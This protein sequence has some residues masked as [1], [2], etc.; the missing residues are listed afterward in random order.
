MTYCATGVAEA[1]FNGDSSV[2]Q[3]S[4]TL[5]NTSQEPLN[6]FSL[7]FRTRDSNATVIYLRHSVSSWIVSLQLSSG[8]LQIVHDVGASLLMS[9]DASVADGIW[10]DVTVKFTDNITSLMIDGNRTGD[11]R[12]LD[13][14]RQNVID[15]N[16]EVF[17]GV[18]A[19][20]SNHF[21]GCLDKV[22]IN[23]LLLPFFRRVELAN[24]TSVERFDAVRITD[25]EIGCHG[26]DVCGS[27]EL[28]QNNGT[29]VDVWNAHVCQCAPGF[30]G[31]FCELNIDECLVGN[32][33]ANGATCVDGIASYS[34]V[35]AAGFS[36]FRY[37]LSCYCMHSLMRLGIELMHVYIIRSS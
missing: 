11:Q 14:P 19:E 37:E 30:N 27:T 20:G 17:V 26:D 22:R 5:R 3:Y 12:I 18:D 36:G 13:S 24:D 1:T 29:C 8:K 9:S 32:E 21:K 34:C 31:T 23:S 28:C 7:R 2:V 16:C 15:S 6:S 4:N 10:H 33:C 25:I 35:C